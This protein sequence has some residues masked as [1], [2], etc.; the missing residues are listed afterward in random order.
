MRL[1]VT[2]GTDSTS[3]SMGG[4]F[5]N[6]WG[7]SITSSFLEALAVRLCMARECEAEA[8]GDP[9]TGDPCGR[10]RDGE[11][12]PACMTQ[13]RQAGPVLSTQSPFSSKTAIRYLRLP[14]THCA[15]LL[16]HAGS[17]SLASGEVSGPSHIQLCSWSG[18]WW[19]G[20]WESF[21]ADSH[22]HLLVPPT[23]VGPPT[24]L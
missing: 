10:T 24:A 15:W 23:A 9:G 14:S 20:Q 21:K 22:T 18:I 16:T 19:G 3:R 6:C 4:T 2:C 1:T 17:D 8:A 13:G 5:R 12:A 7:D 11:A